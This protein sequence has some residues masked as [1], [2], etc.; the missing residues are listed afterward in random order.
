MLLA[1]DKQTD[2]KMFV[3]EGSCW[4][5]MTE[6]TNRSEIQRSELLCIKLSMNQP[7]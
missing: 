6:M 4:L 2:V 5:N 1:T 3:Y 7:R